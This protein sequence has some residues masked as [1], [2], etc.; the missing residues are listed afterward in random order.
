MPR[1]CGLSTTSVCRMGRASKMWK[2]V[3]THGATI[4]PDKV[5]TSSSRYARASQKALRQC[6]HFGFRRF[7]VV[8]ICQYHRNDSLQVWLQP[9]HAFTHATARVNKL[10]TNTT[11]RG[12]KPR[13]PVNHQDVERT[14]EDPI[15]PNTVLRGVR[16]LQVK[17]PARRSEHLF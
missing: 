2:D 15:P 6:I 4:R 7:C 9:D 3:G 8:G 10:K 14:K 17:A 11:A 16:L 5:M 13:A 12:L 1:V